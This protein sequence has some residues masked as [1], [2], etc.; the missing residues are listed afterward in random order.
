[1]SAPFTA[2]GIPSDYP[3]LAA[4]I[5]DRDGRTIAHNTTAR[6][7]TDGID[8]IFHVTRIAT[9][10]PDGTVTLHP[11]G[12][13]TRTTAVRLNAILGP[14]GRVGSIR[15]LWH[16]WVRAADGNGYGLPLYMG[17]TDAY[18]VPAF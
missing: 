13:H 7:G 15:G 3:S 10:H 4:A 2:H 17:H 11:H 1:M 16:L 12:W 5:G 9:V 6:H 18:I 14:R 8:I